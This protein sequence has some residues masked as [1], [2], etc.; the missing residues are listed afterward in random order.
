MVVSQ[1]VGEEV[2]RKGFGKGSCAVGHLAQDVLVSAWFHGRVDGKGVGEGGCGR[3]MCEHRAGVC[4]Q[5][6]FP[7]LAQWDVVTGSA[8]HMSLYYCWW[9]TGLL[10]GMMVV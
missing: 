3:A 7:R 9:H 8:L 4:T 1:W 10:L 5:L 2:V 6:V